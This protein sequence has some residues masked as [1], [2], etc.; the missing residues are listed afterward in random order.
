ME[1]L[2]AAARVTIERL[3]EGASDTL[4]ADVL[5]GLGRTPKEL[6]PKHFYDETGAELFDRIC[7]LPEYYPT[8][9]ERAI[10]ERHADEIA[11]L[12]AAAELLELGSGT[13]AKSRLLLSA[14]DRQGT[15]RRYLPVDVTEAMVERTAA[16][17]TAEY[18]GLAVHGLVCDFETGL[19]AL[20]AP[21]GPRLVAFLGGTIGNYPPRERRAFLRTVAAAMAPEDLLLLGTDLV[22][23]KARLEAAYDDSEGV[24]AAFNRNVLAVINRKLGADFDL[25]AFEHVARFDAENEWIEM[26]LRA[27]APQLVSI[28]S[29]GITAWFAEGE[30]MRTEISAK[31]TRERI[32]AD[33]AAAGLLPLRTYTDDESLF[34]LTLAGPRRS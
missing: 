32:A 15:L 11:E 14:L 31:F 34:A 6:P 10:L 22:K 13:A 23:D 17:L 4:A 16:E 19:H 7:E 25:E 3:L 2:A 8:R 33:L 26:Y 21:A 18:P 28:P 29:L 27:T 30:E 20:P 5:E 12:S 1:P 24:T 9:T